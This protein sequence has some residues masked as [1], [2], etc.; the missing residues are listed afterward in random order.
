MFLTTL[1]FA[2]DINLV[3]KC[4]IKLVS[5]SLTNRHKIEL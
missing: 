2:S 3:F 5:F 4:R 1:A